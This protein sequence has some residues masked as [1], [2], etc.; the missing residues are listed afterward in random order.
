MTQEFHIS[1]TPLGED[2][3]FVRTEKVPVGGLLAEEIVEW[4]VQQWLA[5]ARQLFRDPLIDLLDG[6]SNTQVI[7]PDQIMAQSGEIASPNLVGLGQEMYQELFKDTLRDSWNCAQGI[8]HNRGEILQLRLG[9]K[10]RR[11][12]SLP[13]EVLHAGDRPLATGT[14]VVFSR[15]Q[16]NTCLPKSTRKVSSGQPLKI[17]MAIAAP[18]DKESLQLEKEF[19]ALQQELQKNSGETQIHLDILRQPGREQLT[20]ALEQGQYQVFHYAGH[21]NW[22]NFG[23]EICLV[24]NKTGL[25]E[26]LSGRDLAGLL[27]NNGIEMAVFNSCRGAY[28]HI[29]SPTDEGVEINLA[30]AL[31]KRGIPGVLAM[32]E[33]IPDEVS[34]ILTQLFYRN[35]NQ[36]YPIDLS[37][38]RA[39][40]GLISAYGSHQLYWALPVLY[41]HEKFDAYLTKTGTNITAEVQEMQSDRQFFDQQFDQEVETNSIFA[42]ES[43]MMSSEDSTFVPIDELE[44]AD[45]QEYEYIE[46]WENEEDGFNE[47][48]EDSTVITN[49]L[50]QLTKNELSKPLETKDI[51]QQETP[52]NYQQQQ[53]SIVQPEV[54]EE[55]TKPEEAVKS[56]ARKNN[57]SKL[58]AMTPARVLAPLISVVLSLGSIWVFNNRQSQVN[59]QLPLP[60][61]PVISH[62]Y[63]SVRSVNYT[64]DATQEA[65]KIAIQQ[66]NQNDIKT[67]KMALEKLL[68]Q[69]ALEAAKKVIDAIP[70]RYT[71]NS[72]VNFLKGRLAWENFQEGNQNSLDE[73]ISY[74]EKAVAKSPHIALYQ[75]ALG[76][77]Y[78]TKGDINT[79]YAAWLKVL[80][81]S[82]EITPETEKYRA[83]NYKKQQQNLSINKREALNA[84]AGLGLVMMKSAQGQEKHLNQALKYVQKVMTE[85]GKEF[86]VQQ[87]QKNWLWSPAARQDWDELLNL[88]TNSK[89]NEYN[90]SEELT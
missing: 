86:H 51:Q 14:D 33:R 43:N 71:D 44:D 76:F 84:Y 12:S 28:N 22:G 88:R 48:V 52:E 7:I 23:G 50:N 82:G 47:R 34:L 77:A 74:W 55:V 70:A 63:N 11:L 10:N 24:S 2:E 83:V 6:K 54:S 53:R 15:Y 73:A 59:A 39:R 89:S 80:H 85:A 42:S 66:F 64:T 41:L 18:T 31:V 36:G 1:V 13:W 45:F 25:T 21:S 69:G 75:N 19:E 61:D 9:V 72:D 4:P 56:N 16:P 3:Y 37:L 32:A 57:N 8:A 65:E 29:A 79:A 81:L 5:Q 62:G 58:F 27:V 38:S 40:Q 20:Q 30:E 35:L 49:L 60:P 17:L 68:E 87:L 78:Y 46:S 90:H 67:G 26:S